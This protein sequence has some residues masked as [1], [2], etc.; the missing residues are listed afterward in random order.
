[1]EEM[2]ELRIVEQMRIKRIKKKCNKITLKKGM[3]D[4]LTCLD[5]KCELIKL[6]FVTRYERLNEVL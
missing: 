3:T 1:M 2:Y 4:T 6:C 5:Q